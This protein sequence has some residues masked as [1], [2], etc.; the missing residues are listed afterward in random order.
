VKH[1]SR[2]HFFGGR[3]DAE[4]NLAK[5]QNLKEGPKGDRDRGE[6]RGQTLEK[7]MGWSG[8]K[9]WNRSICENGTAWRR[10]RLG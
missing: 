3:E 9:K 10:T 8:E 5:S 7:P 2:N 4:E 1:S 6:V